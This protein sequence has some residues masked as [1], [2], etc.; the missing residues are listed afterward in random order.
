MFEST[1][2]TL[3]ISLIFLMNMGLFVMPIKAQA[4]WTNILGTFGIGT[5]S[6]S[7][8]FG[9]STYSDPN[10]TRA[11]SSGD[12]KISKEVRQVGNSK[13]HDKITVRS[14]ALVEVMIEV[15]NT[16]SKHNADTIIRDEL[17]GSMVYS[18]NTLRVNGQ[19]GQSG[20]TSNGLRINIP[21]KGKVLITYQMYVCGS[22]GYAIRAYASAPAVGAAT[23]AIIINTESFNVG[24][25][26]DSYLC[27]S[28]YQSG[29]SSTSSN[30]AAV[31]GNP[32]SD[33]TGVNN[34]NSSA[35]ANSTSNASAVS[36]NP[37]EGW[38]GVNNLDSASANTA[39]NN[40]ASAIT[41][42]NP[43]SDWTG[44]QN[45]AATNPFGDWYG[46]DNSQTTTNPFG[47]WYG[48]N[49]NG[50]N[51]PFGDWTGVSGNDS[52]FDSRG[53]STTSSS[54]DRAVAY[55]S[56]TSYANYA[57]AQTNFVAPNTGVDKF[58]PFV[59]AGLL[60]AA[61]IIYR[62]RQLLFN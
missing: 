49:G 33:W 4:N 36:N 13:Y 16:S 22:T 1:R 45:N 57:P 9:N 55:N 56:G 7:G 32:F 51:N 21:S 43:F 44:V 11:Q 46:S 25:Y 14:G 17:G 52:G 2:K 29:N 34:S 40:S 50:N 35:T 39:R 3:V 37:F 23:D 19:T 24:Y 62:K 58:A 42:N 10:S 47:D 6:N 12:I 41:P 60:T 18:Q 59:F 38:T 8:Q 53:Y 28:Q 5:G 30:T 61:F 15:R 20:L 54:V 26:D 31:T 48:S 27:V